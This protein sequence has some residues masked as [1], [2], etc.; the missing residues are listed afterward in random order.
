MHNL[1]A[2][3]VFVRVGETRSFTLAARRI[4]MTPSAASKSVSRLERELGVRLVNR[5]TRTVS[6]TDD[7]ASF[8]VRCR[9]ILADIEEAQIV[10][11]R[12]STVP[13][14]KLRIQIPVGFGRRVIVPALADFIALYPEMVVDI[15]LSDRGVDLAE[16]GLDAVVRIGDLPDSR[17]IARKLC[18]TY[19]ITCAA[20][21]YLRRHGEPKTPD[22][23]EKHRCLT[24]VS[25]QTGHVTNWRFAYEGKHFSKTINGIL[26]MNS[27]ESILDVAVAGAGIVTL[28]NFVVADAIRAGKL[29]LIL[30]EY[31]ARESIISI[32]YLPSRHLSSRMQAFVSFLSD[33]VRADGPWNRLLSSSSSTET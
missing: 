19:F 25:P 28:S 10:L 31:I 9:Q 20:P 27:V 4:G 8:F 24:Y 30:R 26:N 17:L 13:R 23:L 1:N 5:T 21:E 18:E 12:A 29:K 11:T 2:I 32:V 16:E 14:G 6:L 33:L 22:D 7:G 3:T 15:E